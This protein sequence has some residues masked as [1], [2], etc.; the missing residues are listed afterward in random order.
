M[1]SDK[2]IR[3]QRRVGIVVALVLGGV[4][5]TAVSVLPRVGRR[6]RKLLRASAFQKYNDMTRKSAGSRRSPFALLTHVGRR[7]ART[8]HTALGAQA[9]G[10]GF[11]LPLGYGSQ[12][13]WYRNV[14]GTGTCA[15]AWKG[16][17]YQLE[18]PELLSG[19]E[20]LQAWP[21]RQR[22]TLRLAG[23]HDFLWVHKTAG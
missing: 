1:V 16:Q 2:Q 5:L 10:D 6:Y 17:T 13:D 14:M 12:T 11:L 8:Y 15:L 23:I 19:S 22:I 18:R 9:Y 7:S 4:V 3:L 20:A 21:L